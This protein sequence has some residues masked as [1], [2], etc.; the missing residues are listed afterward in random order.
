MGFRKLGSRSFA[1]VFDGVLQYLD[2]QLSAW[3]SRQFAVNYTAFTLY[4]PRDFFV[5][6]CGGRLTRGKSP[7]GWWASKTHELADASM[8]DVAASIKTY[9]VPWFEKT[10]D[11]EGLLQ[12]LLA[13]H[14]SFSRP[15]AH[16]LF[17]IGCCYT[18]LNR[19]TLA[20]NAL[21]QAISVYQEWY[22][23]LPDRKWCLQAITHCEHL[24]TA[25]H[26]SQ[27][28]QLLSEWLDHS[29]QHLKLDKAF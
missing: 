2:L 18:H 9:C 22:R 12:V 7:D 21:E 15:D 25:I 28:E 1:R 29:V 16:F 11:T 24:L 26:K 14:T 20:K 23:E 27:Y 4:S 5:L 6:P 10:R 19:I 13:E 3:G 17:D 8:H